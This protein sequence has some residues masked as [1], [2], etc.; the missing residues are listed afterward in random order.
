MLSSLLGHTWRTV[1]R[2]HPLTTPL[3]PPPT[4][5]MICVLRASLAEKSVGSASASSKLLVCRDCVPPSA[6][7]MAS[8][9]VRMMLL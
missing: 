8:M 4:C 1:T 3:P 7:A 6:A 5:S 9:V 2:G